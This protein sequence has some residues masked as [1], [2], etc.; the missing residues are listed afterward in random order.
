MSNAIKLV[1]KMVNA[2]FFKTLDGNALIKQSKHVLPSV[3]RVP[4]T[5][6]FNYIQF[7]EKPTMTEASDKT[8][9]K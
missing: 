3:S 5:L 2:K 8:E 7:C 1:F 4:S 9:F 6:S